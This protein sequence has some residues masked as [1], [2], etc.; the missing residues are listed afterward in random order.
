MIPDWAYKR[1]VDIYR[2][3]PNGHFIYAGAV[4]GLP[5]WDAFAKYIS[6]HEEPPVDPD[7]ILARK[8]CASR[9]GIHSKDAE[10]YFSGHFDNS[11]NVQSALRA[12]KMVRGESKA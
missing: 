3:T 4:K 10:A 12:I 1:V 11:V 8:A 2:Q 5:L 7:L 6:E 9:P